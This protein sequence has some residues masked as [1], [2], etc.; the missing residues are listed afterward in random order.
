MGIG[1]ANYVYW[2]E[3]ASTGAPFV[4]T[5]PV[6]SGAITVGDVLT[7]TNG[8]V[9]AAPTAAF[10]YQWMK[11]SVIITGATANTYTLV[12]GDIGGIITCV[13]SAVNTAGRINTTSN[14]LGPVAA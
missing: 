4:L 2:Q 3:A 7:T 14:S 9:S 8:T 1:N 12:T 11:D 13:V 6:I 10:S 5:E